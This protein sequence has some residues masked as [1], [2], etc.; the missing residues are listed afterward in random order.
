MGGDIQALLVE[1]LYYYIGPTEELNKSISDLFQM[2][3]PIPCEQS[4]SA[5]FDSSAMSEIRLDLN[6]GHSSIDDPKET[7]FLKL[8]QALFETN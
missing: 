4:R 2:E 8:D 7:L 1:V 3:S 6:P 5:S